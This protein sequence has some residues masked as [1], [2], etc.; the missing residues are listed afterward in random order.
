MKLSAVALAI[1]AAS[2]RLGMSLSARA[3]ST[4]AAVSVPAIK[5][6][7]E[8]GTFILRLAKSET[9]AVNDGTGVL[10]QMILAFFK[11]QTDSAQL[12]D[13]VAKDFYKALTDE[14]GF[15]DAQ[16][17]AFF[18]SLADS[19]GVHDDIEMAFGRPVLDEAAVLE[20][21]VKAFGKALTDDAGVSDLEVIAFFKIL[22][23]GGLVSD[24][25]FLTPGKILDETPVLTDE[26]YRDFSKEI[27]DQVGVTDDWDGAASVDD[28]QVMLFDKQV[29]D[30][31]GVSDLLEAV[32]EF[33][34]SFEDSAA[35][36][37][38]VVLGAG[39]D[40]SDAGLFTDTEIVFDSTKALADNSLVEEQI[41][42]EFV[43]EPKTDSFAAIDDISN[44]FGAVKTDAASIT[45]TGSLRSQGYCDFS[46]FAEDYVGASRT[47]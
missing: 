18:K 30:L 33:L 34:R 12:A 15:T 20:D 24:E 44:G 43:P 39:K 19:A 29:S 3:E 40:V 42:L 36:A 8:L 31:F 47:F 13:E 37:D 25:W 4:V 10:N 41:S 23:D 32:V 16:M 17:M 38:Q 28:D 5:M 11:T 27:A 7:Y 9:V 2:Q 6:A 45:D 22:T 1:S 26:L 35:L 21:A 46:Y 14:A